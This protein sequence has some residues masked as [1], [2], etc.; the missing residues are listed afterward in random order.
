VAAKYKTIDVLLNNAGVCLPER[1]ETKQGF[2][3][4]I[5]VN[6][7][8]HF[9]LTSILMPFI[10]ESKEARIVNV[11]SM[12]HEGAKMNFDDLHLKEGFETVKSYQQSKLANVYFTR[13]LAPSLPKNVKIVSLH[14]GAVKTEVTTPFLNSNFAAKLAW[15]TI[16][17]FPVWLIYKSVKQ[18]AQTS[19]YCCLCPFEDLENGAYYSDCAVKKETFLASDWQAE[20]K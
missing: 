15:Y 5:G 12:A 14:P 20:A 19:L 13:H 10:N 8:G 7:F 9:Y 6:H 18:G 2:E 17:A 4:N 1:K 16:L 11:S 3:A